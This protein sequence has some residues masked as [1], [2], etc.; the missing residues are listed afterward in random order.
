MTWTIGSALR[1]IFAVL[2]DNFGPFFT[3]SLVLCAP[4]LAVDLFDGGIVAT[5]LVVVAA[6]VLV[7]LCLSFGT[8]Q[9][10][11]GARPDFSSLIRHVNRPGSGKLIL[12]G[13][14]QSLVI[15]FGL[16]LVV[17]GLYVLCLWMVALPA[18]IV[19]HT[20]VGHALN[21]SAHLTQERRWHVLGVVVA[22]VLIAAIPLAVI[23]Y[24]IFDEM[25]DVAPESTADSILSW[26]MEAA[27]VTVLGILPT[28]LYVFLRGEKER[29]TLPQIITN[30]D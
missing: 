19:E 5:L 4:V 29:T 22:C 17:P 20:T 2:R 21:R 7:T 6:T 15:G 25:L 27:F 24:I 10:L 14:V 23:D 28:V 9:A 1:M 13:S 8:L 11:S 12:L 26:L 18:M 16:L 3:T 30:L